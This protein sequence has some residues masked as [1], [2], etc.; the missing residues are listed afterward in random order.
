M[1]Y[2]VVYIR[3]PSLKKS[4]IARNIGKKF[5]VFVCFVLSSFVGSWQKVGQK[6]LN[7]DKIG[8]FICFCLFLSLLQVD[9][10]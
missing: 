1:K 10:G 7:L 9:T 6:G 4:V 3:L 8:L 2:C 5:D